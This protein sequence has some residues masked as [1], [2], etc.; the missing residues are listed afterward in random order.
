M[1]RM[2]L[3]LPML[4]VALFLIADGLYSGLSNYYPEPTRPFSLL[5]AAWGALLVLLLAFAWARSSRTL[6]HGIA[7]AMFLPIGLVK[8]GNIWSY[9][10]VGWD[11]MASSFAITLSVGIALALAYYCVAQVARSASA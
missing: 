3:S 11:V 2:L 10:Q 1:K 4:G 5:L 8:L 6:L 7:G 9:F